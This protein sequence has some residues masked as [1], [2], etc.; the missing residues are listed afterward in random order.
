MSIYS[1]E[2]AP[3]QEFP[4]VSGAKPKACPGP[5]GE[6]AQ[7][8]PIA[9]TGTRPKTLVADDQW[10]PTNL[11]LLAPLFYRAMCIH[12]ARSY[13]HAVVYSLV[14]LGLASLVETA[15]AADGPPKLIATGWDNPTPS[16]FRRDLAE[17]E[18]WPF[19]GTVIAPTR[20]GPDGGE[21]GSA[22]A[23]SRE[24]WEESAFARAIADLQAVQPTRA[25]SNFLM[26]IAFPGDVDWFDDAGWK[27]IV[28]HWRLLARVAR[29][30]KLKGL[31]YDAEPYA[32]PFAQ[33][34]YGAQAE[35]DKHSFAE[36]EV[37]ARE[38]GREV[39]RAVAEEF[40]EITILAYRLISDLPMPEP[41][42]PNVSPLLESH[43][44]GL[45]PAFLDGW[46]DVMPP[47]V[48]IFDGNENAYRYNS[49]AEFDHAYVR[50]TTRAPLLLAPENREKFRAQVGVGHGIYLDAHANPPSSPWYIDPMGGTRTARLEANAAAALRA[51]DGYVWIYG[52]KGRWWPPASADSPWWPEKLPGADAALLRA[53]DPDTAARKRLAASKPEENLSRN[54]DF[55]QATANGPIEQ[56]WSWQHEK[57]HGQFDRDP[58]THKAR[59]RN[60]TEGCFG[61]SMPVHPG[62]AYA[63]SARTRTEGQ[64]QSAIR[65][66][67]KNDKGAWT[68]EIR[69]VSMLPQ[70]PADAEGWRVIRGIA[71]VPE[72]AAELVVLLG[73]HGQRDETD[74]AWFDQVIVVPLDPAP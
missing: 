71:R 34:H 5:L 68:D 64:G 33:F 17:F 26:I 37:K 1:V 66:R 55:S 47:T 49:V 35:R 13:R 3:S 31:L 46:L 59:I 45:C 58:D 57:S 22:F 20:T 39:M 18:R 60:V 21:I 25:T 70:E 44:Y 16:R 43:V 38:R 29:Q 15:R 62:A 72:T 30:G 67:W 19:Q 7:P 24:H 74:V 54:A 9:A 51:C 11:H 23:F 65:V 61:Q 6:A 14:L 73:V 52:E 48:R 28:D 10:H 32:E 36:Y 53:V 27:E 2:K 12:I 50:I 69:D 41:G 63:V 8:Q 42:G 56:W 40:P 4:R